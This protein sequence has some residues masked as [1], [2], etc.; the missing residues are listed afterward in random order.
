MKNFQNKSTHFDPTEGTFTAEEKAGKVG[1]FLAYNWFENICFFL[2]YLN[3][4]DYIE[5]LFF[6]FGENS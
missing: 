2:N 5:F 1:K 3:H 4:I 6:I